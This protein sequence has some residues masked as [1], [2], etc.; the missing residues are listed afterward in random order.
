MT[1]ALQQ[2][3]PRALALF[4]GI[5]RRAGAAQ[6]SLTALVV[7]VVIAGALYGAAMGGWRV[8]EGDRWKLVVFVAIKSPM[9]IVVTTLIVL[10]GFFVLNSVAGLRDDF[11]DALRAIL[12]GQAG[13]TLSLASL[14]PVT[15]FIYLTG[16]SHRLATLTNAGMFTIAATVAQVVMFRW[17]KPL[18]AKSKAHLAM[19]GLWLVMYAFVGMQMGWILRP[20]I[21]N[22]KMAPAFFREDAFT[23]AYVVIFKLFFS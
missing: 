2:L 7:A 18:I 16:V 3:R 5:A 13:L 23:N 6:P 12:I 14:A 15:Q 11:R 20:F 8:L 10:P 1:H 17:Y 22:P 19:L 21:G 9:L 4:D